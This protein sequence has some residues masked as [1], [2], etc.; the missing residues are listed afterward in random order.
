MGN[1]VSWLSKIC[2][3]RR[4]K[5]QRSG[6]RGTSLHSAGECSGSLPIRHQWILNFEQGGG[7][8]VPDDVPFARKS[9]THEKVCNN[10]KE[11]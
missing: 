9:A 11:F 6:N 2:R 4:L 7:G 1:E 5:P 3:E 10:L 8:L